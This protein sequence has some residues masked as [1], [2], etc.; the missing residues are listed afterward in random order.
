MTDLSRRTFMRNSLAAGALLGAAAGCGQQTSSPGAN[1]AAG[2]APVSWGQTPPAPLPEGAPVNIVWI[3]LDACRA[4][5]L[6]CYGYERPTSPHLDR[7]A[8]RGVLFENHFAQAGHTFFSVPSYVT[9]RYFPCMYLDIQVPEVLWRTPPPEE[10]LVST[11]LA[12]NGMATCMIS[13]HP[14][15]SRASRL[16]QSFQ[17]A[18]FLQP[19]NSSAV[20]APLDA[21]VEQALAW[22]DGAQRPPFFMYLHA[23]DTHWPHD[24][25]LGTRYGQWCDPD[26]A[27]SAELARIVANKGTFTEAD[28]AFC[29]GLYDGDILYADEMTGR[30]LAGLE[31]RGLL[32]ATIVVV[33]ADHGEALAEDGVTIA[34]PNECIADE[35]LHVPLIMSGPGLPRGARIAPLTENVD[36]IP[37][38]LELIGATT[39]AAVDGKSLMPLLAETDPP[40]AL[41]DWTFAKKRD[42]ATQDG[43]RTVVLRTLSHKYAV[44]KGFQGEALWTVPD[45]LGARTPCNLAQNEPVLEQMRGVMRDA[46]LLRWNAWRGRPLDSKQPFA[47]AFSPDIASPPEAF[48][49]GPG[50]KRDN[51]WY[52]AHNDLISTPWVED[53]PPITFE[54]NVPNARYEIAM[55]TRCVPNPHG[56]PGGAFLVK[57]QDDPEFKR[58]ASDYENHDKQSL[59]QDVVIGEYEVTGGVFRI[60]LDEADKKH[61]AS[62][63]KLIFRPLAAGAAPDL[64]PKAEREALR[65]QLEGL[66][67]L[68]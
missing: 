16:F 2:P 14:W 52:L 54:M 37:T 55:T 27:R 34:H 24:H 35:V 46:I 57:C 39:N 23:M 66:G 36:L 40:Q 29:T 47:V 13:A 22:I 60:T 50:N 49:A 42:Y 43:D 17:D 65:E 30:L 15:M 20:Y 9:G 56:L 26:Y 4:R 11:M 45:R 41:H 18:F 31:Q 48:D 32:D 6:A 1:P 63:R 8:K 38:L 51:K 58:V 7:L 61:W 68:E 21:L 44:N 33:T 53:A 25:V 62:A 5:N 3:L 19:Q 59:W 28:R 12:G 10:Q 67:Y 64:L